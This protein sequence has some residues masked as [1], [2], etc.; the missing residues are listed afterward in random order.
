M[1]RWYRPYIFFLSLFAQ[2]FLYIFI[3]IF[4]FFCRSSRYR[5][6]SRGAAKA[7]GYSYADL[8]LMKINLSS[9]SHATRLLPRGVFSIYLCA[10]VTLF[11]PIIVSAL[12]SGLFRISPCGF[13]GLVAWMDGDAHTTHPRAHTQA[14]IRREDS[15]DSIAV[16]IVVGIILETFKSL[17]S[18]P[19]LESCWRF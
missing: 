10:V 14:W 16:M 5:R 7:E 9:H 2:F 3:V 4:F 12:C 17:I 15:S 18:R 6:T 1:K 8:I 13:G 19:R 11:S